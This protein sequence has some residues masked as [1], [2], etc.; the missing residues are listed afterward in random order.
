MT[1]EK[2]ECIA[3]KISNPQADTSPTTP[4]ANRLR[5]SRGPRLPVI[6]LAMRTVILASVSGTGNLLFI[7]RLG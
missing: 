7:R 3:V 1:Q 5:R 4:R 2:T 6:G